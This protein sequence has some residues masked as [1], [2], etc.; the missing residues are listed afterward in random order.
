MNGIVALSPTVVFGVTAAALSV[1]TAVIC[2]R[3]A[4][5]HHR[6][7]A[8]GFTTAAVASSLW[9]GGYG[10]QLAIGATYGLWTLI[11]V[12]LGAIFFPFGWIVF[13]LTY[14]GHKSALTKR[15]VALLATVPVGLFCI[16]ITH[17]VHGL[18]VS[19]TTIEPIG[20]V[21]AL[22]VVYGP[23]YALF[24]A[25]V[26]TVS[27]ASV[28]LLSRSLR[29][30]SGVYTK[31]TVVLLVA[32]VLPLVGISISLLQFRTA[33]VDALPFVASGS[34]LLVLFGTVRYALFDV[35]SIARD[36]VVNRMRD[37]VIVLNS[38]RQIVE[39]NS[40]ARD[41][42]ELPDTVIGDDARQ[43]RPLQ[44]IISQL[45]KTQ[46]DHHPRPDGGRFAES[47]AT[48]TGQV[49]AG[50]TAKRNKKQAKYDV[51]V[52][53]RQ[54]LPLTDDIDDTQQAAETNQ[55]D[56]AITLSS[57][58]ERNYLV[59]VQSVRMTAAI[60]GQLLVFRDIT[61][62]RKT[63]TQFRSLI[64]HTS[65]IILV[66]DKEGCLRYSSPTLTQQ[67]GYTPQ[68]LL[69]EQVFSFIHEDEQD[70]ALQQFQRVVTTGE[71]IRSRYRIQDT[72]ESWRMYECVA[73]NHLETPEIE[74]II[75][76]AR[77][78]TENH[79]YQRRLQ[80]MNRV[81][82][83]DLRNDM[84]VVLGH[85]D[86]LLEANNGGTRHAQIIRRKAMSLVELG[87]KVRRIDEELT[88]KPVR[89]RTNISVIVTEEVTAICDSY[90]DATV[91]TQI[92]NECIIL[93]DSSL[94]VA[95][96]NLL[97]NAIEHNTADKPTVTVRLEQHTER[98]ELT[99]EDNGPGIPV[100]ERRVV[101]SGT[102]TPLEHVSGLGLWLVIW[103]VESVKG[104]IS[105]TAA[106]DSGTEV[107]CTFSLPS[108]DAP[109]GDDRVHRTS[110]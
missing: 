106:P 85:A 43:Y 79:R 95:V 103:I 102:E 62:R 45:Q 88:T 27:V 10:M 12:V 94:S 38:D 76:S 19:E 67:L 28:G 17:P 4:D 75:I 59:T 87:E 100:G 57:G 29:G 70:T 21:D 110:Q 22:V 74:G 97:E 54:N 78:V 81:L 41:G 66:L 25:Y 53:E 77:E 105:F 6:V 14:T 72:D 93:G 82:R 46:Q 92:E 35:R 52:A 24:A 48:K 55:I 50:Q 33:S 32:T 65:D 20:G 16:T 89:T 63:E 1:L 51:S 9:V 83:H 3:Q 108:F 8:I 39:A 30:S 61:A 13:I 5:T 99:I 80:V 23:A 44:V 26:I 40:A 68:E 98:V 34:I 7:A 104:E 73:L 47:I 107:R 91:R 84:N 42:L 37:G 58:E 86:L 71:Q 31:Q 2:Y 69:G 64:E 15:T 49:T 56:L 101:E 90:P 96:R 60:D 36:E 11:P 18:F 109:R